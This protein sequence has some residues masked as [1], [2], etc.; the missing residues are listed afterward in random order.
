MFSSKQLEGILSLKKYLPM[1]L[2]PD[3]DETCCEWTSAEKKEDGALHLPF[4]KYA[5][6]VT[7]IVHVAYEHDI[8]M[9]D[10]MSVLEANGIESSGDIKDYSA[11]SSDLALAVLTR[12]IRGERFCEGTIQSAIKD[13]CLEKVICPHIRYL[14]FYY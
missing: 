13:D 7:D 1:L 4:V 8:V 9:P 6:W 10:Y 12:V 3:A 2:K 5:S 14:R 11:L